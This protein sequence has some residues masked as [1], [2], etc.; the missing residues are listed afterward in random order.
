MEQPS[1]AGPVLDKIC[2]VTVSGMVARVLLQLHGYAGCKGEQYE[3]CQ[4]AFGFR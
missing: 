4:E 3:D 2:L 1:D